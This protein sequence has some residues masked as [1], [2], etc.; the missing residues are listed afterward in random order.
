MTEQL[1]PGNSSRAEIQARLHEVARLLQTS[2]SLNAE[3]RQALAELVD[4]LG[5]S[6]NK[7]D[8]PAGEIEH[9]AESTAHLAESLHHQHDQT[10]LSRARERLEEAVVKTEARS[11]FI[12]GVAR[13]L[14]DA[15]ANLGI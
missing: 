11:P 15:L 13:R 14:L 1:Q 12:S 4:S 9:L 8:I 6:L 7:T 10:I 2:D 3:S 5:D